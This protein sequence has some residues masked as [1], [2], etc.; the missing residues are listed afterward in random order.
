MK[1][2]QRIFAILLL[3]GAFFSCVAG[4]RSSEWKYKVIFCD[5]AT[6]S[7]RYATTN[8]ITVVPLI[9][10]G[11]FDT[12]FKSYPEIIGKALHESKPALTATSTADLETAWKNAYP[13]RSISEFYKP[14]IDN[15]I[16]DITN[17]DSAWKIISTQ[18]LMISRIVNGVAI[19]DMEHRYKRRA[20][21]VIELWNVKTAGV[22]WRASAEG[23]E[24]DR[25]VS[26]ADFILSGLT[27]LFAKLPTVYSV[28]NA[29]KW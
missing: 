8:T 22:V 6:L 5:T 16:L 15:K 7:S 13:G 26:D 28:V 2:P 4:S 14:I 20:E 12:L 19:S 10:V 21:I 25:R 29:E 17:S 24:M 9:S 27:G 3:A 1:H 11:K 18:Y 23:Y